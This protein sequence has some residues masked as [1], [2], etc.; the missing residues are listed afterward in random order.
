MLKERTGNY[1]RLSDSL[2]KDKMFKELSCTQQKCGEFFIT[3]LD[4]DFKI[5]SSYILKTERK[6]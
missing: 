3:N 2:W 6:K 5:F 1:S 4:C